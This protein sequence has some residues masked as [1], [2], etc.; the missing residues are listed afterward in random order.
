MQTPNAK[1]NDNDTT[2]AST[3]PRA[4]SWYKHLSF[5]I[6][7]AMVLGAIV[8][9]LW[10]QHADAWKPLGD[11]FIKLVRMLVAPIIFCTVVHGIAS[12]GQ[13]KKVGRV[14]IKSLIYFE[15][16]TTIALV[17]ALLLVN[18]WAPGAGMHVDLKT[19]ADI[20]VKAPAKPISFGQFL[21]NLV[22]ASA[23]GAFAEGEVIPVLFFSLM[24]AFGLLALGSKGKPLVDGIHSVTQ[25][26]F[27]MIGFVM[28]VAPIGA[29]G[30]I[31]FTVGKFGLV[32][33]LALGKL[34]SEF[35]VC[36]LLF[37]AIVLAPIAYAA[38]V[39]ILR[40]IRY[41]A[42]ELMIVVGTSSGESVFPSVMAKLRRLGV[43]ESIVALVLPTGYSFNHDGTCLYW[44]T[45]SVFLAQALGIHLTIGQQ[46]ALLATML[47]TSK[48]G[49]GVA[50]SAIVVLATTLSATGAV[51]VASVGLILGVHS[52]LSSA[53]VPVNVLGNSLA[54]IVIGRTERAV[55]L[56]TLQSE[57][58][59]GPEET[60]PVSEL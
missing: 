52:L 53:F 17:L 7:L 30:A 26:L 24:F 56:Q 13:A 22:P 47:F 1:A 41:F 33:L 6:L 2:Q 21:L 4:R 48:G 10:P 43:E 28:Y 50:G 15:I 44:A 18:L 58:Q 49:A 60:A 12:V 20:G 38:G 59:R 40:L 16:V 29:F 27:K 23:V 42:A 46:L 45:V 51:P 39:N 34:V 19:L 54:T 35:Y 5:Q 9:H 25:V 3:A 32:S 55:D 14:A 37:V 36:C 57:L 8:G 11:L 31:A